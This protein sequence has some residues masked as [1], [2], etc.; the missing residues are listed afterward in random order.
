MPTDNAKGIENNFF[1]GEFVESLHKPLSEFHCTNAAGT[2]HPTVGVFVAISVVAHPDNPAAHIVGDN[3][4][5]M[6]LFSECRG[7]SSSCLGSF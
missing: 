5:L 2:F 7:C 3:G 1:F 6:N 4:L